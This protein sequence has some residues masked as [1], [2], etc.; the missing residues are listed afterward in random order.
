MFIL[1]DFTAEASDGKDMNEW[2][3]MEAWSER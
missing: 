3:P 2:K 1:V